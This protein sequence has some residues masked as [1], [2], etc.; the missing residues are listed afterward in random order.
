MARKIPA[1]RLADLA[2]CA[3][4]VFIANGYRRTQMADVAD[5]LGVAKGTLYLYVEG[6]E[7]LF[8][9][10][11]RY[12]DAP[13]TVGQQ[14]QSLPVSTPK[15]GATAA[16]VRQ[17]LAEN[18]TLPAL[19]AAL[20]RKR[21][22][23]PGRE[24]GDIVREMYGVLA[25]NRRSIEL[26]DRSA[27]DH[28]DLA[29]IWFEAGRGGLMAALEQYLESRIRTGQLRPVPDVPAAARLIIETAAFWAVHRHWDPQPRAV[30]ENTALETV[31]RFAVGALA[32]G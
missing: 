26:L 10:A 21:A 8:D 15:P 11:L 22:S 29:A 32:K 16:Y 23:D 31:V 27:A 13:E 14:E 25:R 9:L 24:L 5:A 17:R 6:K 4:R 1:G 28:P 7:A 19:T 20:G 18:Q 30:D 3:V 2:D 12:A